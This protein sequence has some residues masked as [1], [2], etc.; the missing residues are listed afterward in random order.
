MK[1]EYLITLLFIFAALL[2]ASAAWI[3]QD[4]SRDPYQDK[5][6]VGEL[7]F[8]ELDS[9]VKAAS[10]QIV[11]FDAASGVA[12]PFE[13]RKVKGEWT[14][15]SHYNY[16]ANAQ[17]QMIQVVTSLMELRVI[18]LVS[19]DRATHGDYGVL[20]PDAQNVGAKEGSVG[21]RVVVRDE[22]ENALLDLVIGK[23]V[24]E[25]SNKRYV[26]RAK[27]DAVYIVG[28]DPQYLT[29]DFAEW[30][31]RALLELQ[32]WEIS[33]LYVRDYSI[34]SL[35]IG[36]TVRG[37]IMLNYADMEQ[38]DWTLERCERPTGVGSWQ[39]TG[40]PP[41]KALDREKLHECI[42]AIA[43]MELANV[44]AKPAEA[45]QAFRTAGNTKISQE[46]RAALATSGFF[47]VEGQIFSVQGEIQTYTKQ[48]IVY[49]LRFGA[50]PEP[51]LRYLW[52][53]ADWFKESLPPPKLEPIPESDA[54][55]AIV[56][57]RNRLILQEHEKK[58]EEVQKKVDALNEKFAPWI[59]IISDDFFKKIHLGFDNVFISEEEAKKQATPA[60]QH[61]HD[62][63][64]CDEN[65]AH[66]HH[67]H[68][69][70]ENCPHHHAG[71]ECDE[72]CPHYSTQ[73]AQD[74]AGA[75]SA[76]GTQNGGETEPTDVAP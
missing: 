69:C 8:P 27:Q 48:G 11:D 31:D 74:T 30:I 57:A 28:L 13:L 54:D 45:A 6:R 75:Q 70:D 18:R 51:G 53:S 3:L 56:E 12:K 65:C 59:Y 36:P 49:L 32:P 22:K 17:E 21:K 66:H 76:E 15:P 44:V 4:E 33:G 39:T 29:T 46:T 58:L 16:P 34:E 26:R 68:E 60:D 35:E 2:V 24:D 55:K 42:D 37:N 9:I 1:K 67:E 64:V 20:E 10:L 71:H 52:I 7:L 47:P 40:M 19:E 5:S 14:L 50:S 43:E 62:D 72:N 63:H 38:P 61:A 73:D 23:Q 25:V 41:G